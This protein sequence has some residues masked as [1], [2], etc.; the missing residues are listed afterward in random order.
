MLLLMPVI[1]CI[2]LSKSVSKRE[3]EICPLSA[4]SL[5]F[6]KARKMPTNLSFALNS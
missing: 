2:P 5:L 3:A 4:K 1:R 6:L